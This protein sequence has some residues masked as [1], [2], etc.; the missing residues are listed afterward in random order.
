[1]GLRCES[2]FLEVGVMEKEE[3][4]FVACFLLNFVPIVAEAAETHMMLR[5]E[6]KVHPL[7]EFLPG[8]STCGLLGL[9]AACG[10]VPNRY[11]L[12]AHI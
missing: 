9:A 8:G 12:G 3:W 11:R 5:L 6:L 4:D 1:M 10:Q 2:E 7:D